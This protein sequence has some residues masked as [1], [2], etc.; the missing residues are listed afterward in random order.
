[1]NTMETARFFSGR[2]GSAIGDLCPAPSERTAAFR[3]VAGRC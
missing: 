3:E 1:M 2:L